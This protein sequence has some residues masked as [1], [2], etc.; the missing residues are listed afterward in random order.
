MVLL[1]S[2]IQ[3]GHKEGVRRG[4]VSMGLVHLR[5]DDR[6]RRSVVCTQIPAP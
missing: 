3:R 2:L 6:D 5:V 1:G 4:I